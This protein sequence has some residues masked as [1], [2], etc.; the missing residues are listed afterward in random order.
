MNHPRQAD[1]EIE[2]ACRGDGT[3][4]GVRGEVFIDLG[5]YV[6]QWVDPVAHFGAML[7][8]PFC[9]PNVRI[10]STALLAN[11]TPS[12]TSRAPGRY[13][14]SFLREADRFGGMRPWDR[15]RRDAA[16]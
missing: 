3:I 5:A 12:G 8:G 16:G 14:A 13:E 4:L 7:E 10:T 1:C 2:I 15:Q 6:D 11:K 9:V